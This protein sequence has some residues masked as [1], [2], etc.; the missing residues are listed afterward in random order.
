[1]KGGAKRSRNLIHGPDE[2]C[3]IN[4]VAI[5]FMPDNHGV[6]ATITDSWFESANSLFSNTCLIER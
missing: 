6:A 4:T 1:L 5:G 2:R 3:P